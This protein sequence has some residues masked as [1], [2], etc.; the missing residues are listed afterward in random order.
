M[1]F[2]SWIV[3]RALKLKSKNGGCM[4]THKSD[5]RKQ[6]GSSACDVLRVSRLPWL[7]LVEAVRERVPWGEEKWKKHKRSKK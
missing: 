6:M 1:K 2:K 7:L 3:W 5:A 4:M